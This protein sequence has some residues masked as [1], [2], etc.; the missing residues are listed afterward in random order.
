MNAKRKKREGGEK[1]SLANLIMTAQNPYNKG[2]KGIKL[3]E[4]APCKPNTAERERK[5]ILKN[6]T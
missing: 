5:K 4:T 2:E 1:A 3:E 6:F